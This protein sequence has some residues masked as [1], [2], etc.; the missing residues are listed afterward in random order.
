[1]GNRKTLLYL[2]SYIFFLWFNVFNILLKIIE[3]IYF[4]LLEKLEYI[5]VNRKTKYS[6]LFIKLYS[7][8]L[9]NSFIK[10]MTPISES[11]S[12]DLNYKFFKALVLERFSSSSLFYGSSNA[13]YNYEGYDNYLL[14]LKFK[15][16]I[17]LEYVFGMFPTII[18]GFIIVPSMY[19]LYSN[20]TDI[21]PCITV[22]I[23]GHQ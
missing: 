7:F 22:K 6:T 1:M 2:Q 11:R 17:N 23:V 8:I 9:G 10:G 5:L 21:N 4:I 16:S 3:Y 15:H 14:A 18:I 13:L 12:G 20:E 19:L